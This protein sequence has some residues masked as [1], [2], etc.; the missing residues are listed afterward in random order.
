MNMLQF[1]K[2]DITKTQNFV[3]P[4]NTVGAMGKG[5]ALDVAKKFPLVEQSYKSALRAQ[6]LDI[7]KVCPVYIPGYN[8][9]L[10]PTKKDWHNPS[11]LEYVESGLR[12]L[13]K[14]ILKEGLDLGTVAIPKLGC[15]LGGLDWQDAKPLI[16]EAARDFAAHGVDTLV[17]V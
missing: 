6:L 16:E 11:T 13:V 10:L 9:Y 8:I 14:T 12:G 15:G 7:G 4:V 1:T 2:G 3:V 5:L 17:Y